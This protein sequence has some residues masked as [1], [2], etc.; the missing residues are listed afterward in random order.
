MENKKAMEKMQNDGVNT[1]PTT[2]EKPPFFSKRV[3]ALILSGIVLSV[4]LFAAGLFGAAHQIREDAAAA[5]AALTKEKL[6]AAADVDL[7][8]ALRTSTVNNVIAGEAIP[9]YSTAEV[10]AMDM[11]QPSGVTVS[12]L[13]LVTQA[14]LVGLEPAFVKA[15]QDYG[16]N[17]LFVMAIAA[18]ESANGTINGAGN[19]MFGWGGGSIAFS[20]KEECIDTVA[21]GLANNY[22]SPGGSLYTGNTISAVNTRYAASTA[23][24]DRVAAN[25]VYYYSIISENHNAA[26]EKLQ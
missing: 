16:I 21:R 20:S 25:M 4:V 8:N 1:D 3:V 13:E 2:M 10:M 11:S 6:S 12:D 22:L 18:H 14:G 24:D 17:C 15:E 19:N 7:A 5:S 9:A 23:W 26:L